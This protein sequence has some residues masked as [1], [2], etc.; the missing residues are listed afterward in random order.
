[1]LV[2]RKKQQ[3]AFTK[4]VARGLECNLLTHATRQFPVRVNRMGEPAARAF[5]RKAVA[6][7]GGFGIEDEYEMSRYLDLMFLLGEDFCTDASLAWAAAVLGNPALAAK[8]KMDRLCEH[9]R[10]H[11]G[12]VEQ[13]PAGQGQAEAADPMEHK[14][15]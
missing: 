3:E 7:C 4:A 6:A 1:M 5:V 14:P 2:I 15:W 10:Q 11:L 8:E 12:R 9:A 13:G